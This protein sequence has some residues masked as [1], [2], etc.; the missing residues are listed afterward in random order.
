ML[1]GKICILTTRIGW[2]ALSVILLLTALSCRKPPVVILPPAG[3]CNA[4]KDRIIEEYRRYNVNLTPA[5]SDFTRTAHSEYF[6]FSELSVNSPYTWALVRE[7]LTIEKSSGYG[8]DKLRAEYGAARIV[9]SAFRSPQK[10]ASIGGASQSRHMYGDAVDLRNVSGSDQ[11]YNAMVN[12][13]NA[14]NAD[15]I[16]PISGPCQKACVHADWRNTP[17]RYSQ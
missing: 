2:A 3:G 9:N 10:N 15:Y 7:P 11:E 1:R 12:A 13:A 4:E 5:C 17:G 6:A 8:L 14:A 16:E